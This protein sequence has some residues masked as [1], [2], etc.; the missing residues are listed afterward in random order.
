M[1][2]IL[3]IIGAGFVTTEVVDQFNGN[4][5]EVTPGVATTNYFGSDG[6][7]IIAA[8]RAEERNEYKGL[9]LKK[10][11]RMKIGLVFLVLGFL[12]QLLSNWVMKFV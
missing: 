7:P 8:Q 9:E 11:W 2:L 5:F 6:T 4:N 3:D 12:F 1:G 10:Y